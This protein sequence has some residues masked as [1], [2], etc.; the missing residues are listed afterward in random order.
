MPIHVHV[1][2][3]YVIYSQEF[4]CVANETLITLHEPG[5]SKGTYHLFHFYGIGHK[6]VF[7]KNMPKEHVPSK[8]A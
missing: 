4:L 3:P 1:S 6:S 8:C 5:F 7:N 2:E